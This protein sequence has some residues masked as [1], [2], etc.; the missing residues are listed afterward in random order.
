MAGP[1]AEVPGGQEL[2]APER[3]REDTLIGM[4]AAAA[5]RY[6]CLRWAALAGMAA[7]TLAMATTVPARE[8]SP[9]ANWP[10][11]LTLAVLPYQAV[12]HLY[13]VWTPVAEYLT[14]EMGIPVKIS[15]S[16]LYEDYVRE[17]L[18]TRPELA[19]FHPLHYLTAHRDGGYEAFVSPG[20]RRSDS[21][22]S[23]R[24]PPSPTSPRVPMV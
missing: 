21:G 17:V 10:Q 1:I 4:R 23:T 2:G 24:T 8:P 3:G 13:D 6:R 12:P 19:F 14:R 5:N 11:R 20:D 22:T 18:L 9:R 15:T 16:R 7:L